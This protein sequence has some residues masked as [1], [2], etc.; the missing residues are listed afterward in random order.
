[1]SDDTDR[2]LAIHLPW[3]TLL[4]IIAAIALVWAWRELAWLVMLLLI[5]TIIA[6]GLAPSVEWVERRGWPRWVA[7]SAV[8]LLCVGTLAAFVA[9]TW[10]S[11]FAESQHLGERFQVIEAELVARAPAA[12]VGILRRT[13]GATDTSRLTSYAMTI[14]GGLLW[15]AGAFALA[16]ILVVYLLIEAE[17]TYQWLRGF[18]AAPLRA[19]FDRTAVEA[20]AAAYSYVVGNVIT[21]I[22]AGV[23]VFVWLAA[24]QVPG[25]L[26]L[27]VLA[28]VCDFVPVL[29]FFI[30]CAPAVVMGAAQSG[31]VALAIVPIYLAYHF[32]ENYVIGP[33]VY[34]T[35]LRLSN[36][37][38]LLAFAVGAEIGGVVGALVAL[39][40]A[41]V[42][43]TIER[44]WLREPFGED[45]VK[46]HD[47]LQHAEADGPPRPGR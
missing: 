4:K 23:Y 6:V 47:R 26:L 45:V 8:V 27:S 2:R 25:A 11:L 36:V 39:P 31:T 29:G 41:A 42:Y 40:V 14:G 18:V 20:R 3:S 37:A 30:A 33:R 46:E 32:L 10:S 7:A 38:V 43:P 19:R 13:E 34:G 17:T 15:G 35:R 28:F 5:A 24:L 16:W 1:M 44:L 12:V 9:F 21:S 22:L